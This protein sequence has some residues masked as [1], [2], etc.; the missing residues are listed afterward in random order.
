V[1]GQA[2]NPLFFIFVDKNIHYFI[3]FYFVTKAKES[4][5]SE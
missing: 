2:T 4:E 5:V 1:G 3:P